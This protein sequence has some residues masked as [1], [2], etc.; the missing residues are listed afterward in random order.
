MKNK[1]TFI[2]SLAISIILL[3]TLLYCTYNVK[4]EPL[5]GGERDEH[6]CLGPA[7]YS[8]NET[9][10]ACVREW[11]LDTTQ[12]EVAKIAITSKIKEYGLTIIEISKDN[13]LGCFT[14]K[15]EVLGHQRTIGVYSWDLINVS[16]T[17]DECIAQ[18]GRNLNVVSREKCYTNE[19]NIGKVTDFIS[20]NIC[21][22]PN[23]YCG[24]ETGD[25]CIQVWEPV[26]GFGDFGTKTF[27]NGCVA[28]LNTSVEYYLSG[29]C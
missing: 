20:P 29:E 28:C 1:L 18:G 4:K 22:V 2:I 5:I 13:C 7:G 10:G 25:Y 9:L 23:I 3:I 16:L 6:G 27:S 12:R 24:E 21:C 8:Y 14:V 15:V 17:S 11:E 26:C 19:T